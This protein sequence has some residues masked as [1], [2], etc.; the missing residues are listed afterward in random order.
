MS[1][2]TCFMRVA[3]LPRRPHEAIWEMEEIFLRIE[4][5]TNL[6]PQDIH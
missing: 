4:K 1:H 6:T 5:E 2:V 3:L